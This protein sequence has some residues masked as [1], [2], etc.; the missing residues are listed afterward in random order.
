MPVPELKILHIEDSRADAN[1]VE[2]LL[3]RANSELKVIR[4]SNGEEAMEWLENHRISELGDRNPVDLLLLDLKLP[5]M[6]GVEFLWRARQSARLRTIPII[7]LSSV[8]EEGRVREAYECGANAYVVKPESVY[9]YQEVLQG[10]VTFWCESARLP[11]RSGMGTAAQGPVSKQLPVGKRRMRGEVA[12]GIRALLVDDVMADAVAIKRYLDDVKGWSIDVGIANA[13]PEAEAIIKEEKTDL[14]ILDYKLPEES[15]IVFL[16][17]LR[18]DG[19]Q[20]GIIM[21]TGQ[22]DERIAA[23]AVRLGADDY[24]IKNEA[25]AAVLETSLKYVLRRV[26]ER[27]ANDLDALTGLYGRK[28]F[29]LHLAQEV[30]RACGDE[31]QL[32]VCVADVDKFKTINDTHGHLKG[33]EVLKSLAHA[34]R[35]SIRGSDFVARYGG[36]EFCLVL[37]G[38][39][40]EAARATAD[41]IRRTVAERKFQG[42]DGQAIQ[43]TCSIGLGT[44]ESG[45][46]EQPARLF[47][48]ADWAMF[49]AKRSGGNMVGVS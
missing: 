4:I 21:L 14:V 10:L 32:T 8:V 6:Q 16:Q 12:A 15:G 1:T 25:N 39:G 45:D 47:E 5:G 29:D 13:A 20:G 3:E 46:L 27:H 33:D 22:G 38:C 43:T 35:Q 26:E 11:G 9:D 31:S 48:R 28:A 17:R 2:R 7:V 37:A 41:R 49:E 44:V 23:K 42:S 19:F 40:L 36:D 24:I 30:R 34:L 18:R